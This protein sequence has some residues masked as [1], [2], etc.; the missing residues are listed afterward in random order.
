MDQLAQAQQDRARQQEVVAQLGQ[1]AL[2]GGPADAL[3]RE[4]VRSAG[5]IL[6]VEYCEVLEL[7]P[8]DR[9]V[10][11]A[12]LPDSEAMIGTRFE[13]GA[14]SLAG[15]A[16]LC[17]ESIVMADLAHETRFTPHPLM[18][19]QGI[20]SGVNV[21]IPGRGRP[22]GVLN[23]L[24]T[25][26]RAFDDQ[27]TNFLRAVANILG[28]AID[29]I[30]TEDALHR[31]ELEAKRLAA[32]EAVM[33][34]IGRI[35]SSTLR[36]EEVYDQ[37]AAEVK[38]VLL[39]DRISILIAEPLTGRLVIRYTAGE[40]VPGRDPG[41]DIPLAGTATEA[42]MQ[43]GG[44]LLVQPESIDQ[45]MALYPGYEP[46]YRA[47]YPSSL[48]AAL[49]AEGQAF[50]ALMLSSRAPGR[51]GP[52]EMAIVERVASQ[53]GGAIAHAQLL[54]KNIRA[55]ASLKASEIEAHRLAREKAVMAEIGRIITSTLK[56]E[57]VYG[58]SWPR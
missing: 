18:R 55:E 5:R 34:N 37:F 49:V 57:E 14:A 56:I 58:S 11:R 19:S 23:A 40:G 45:L 8:E 41:D 28:A 32:E 29:R 24:S 53:I 47:G 12:A 43:T 44:C 30:L 10:V 48:L 4:A 6:Q 21:I 51:Y 35:I 25:R 15:Y 20:V 7:L 42:V 54:Q 2:A 1:R 38:Q 36:I 33:A 27:D 22:Y 31:S 13:T 16:L 9:L 52:R 17:G 50:G 46:Y 3:F 26:H 39:F